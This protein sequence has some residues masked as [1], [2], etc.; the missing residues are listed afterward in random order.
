MEQIDILTRRLRS[1]PTVKT[2]AQEYFRLVQLKYPSLL[3][4][5]LAAI[6]VELACQQL[7]EPV[8]KVG[9]SSYISVH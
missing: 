7:G 1:P 4:S 2:T 8:D 3:P 6:C 5:S 9:V